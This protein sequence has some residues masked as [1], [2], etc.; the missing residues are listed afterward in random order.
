MAR[1]GR[2]V[3]ARRVG[4]KRSER[5]SLSY[6]TLGQWKRVA[7]AVSGWR[8]QRITEPR[9]RRVARSQ[10]KAE[11]EEVWGSKEAAARAHAPVRARRMERMAVRRNL[12]Q[13][14]AER[15]T[16]VAA[17]RT[18]ARGPRFWEA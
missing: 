14:E 5:F 18:H 16:V 9:R 3:R 17:K 13:R 7:K 12:I 2:T 10:R 4:R 8:S 1:M 6:S 11:A 15:A